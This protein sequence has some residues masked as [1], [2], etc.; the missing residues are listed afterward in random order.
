M[1]LT[2]SQ[3]AITK[4][5]ASP[6]TVTRLGARRRLRDE[7]ADSAATGGATLLR[8]RE[9]SYGYRAKCRDTMPPPSRSGGTG[10]RAGLKIRFPPGSVG[11][12]PTFGISPS[13]S[14]VGRRREERLPAEVLRGREHAEVRLEPGQ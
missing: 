9:K 3:R 8:S 10:R 1:R 11:S 13:E 4:T 5:N 12:I 14:R 6:S 7:E 2:T